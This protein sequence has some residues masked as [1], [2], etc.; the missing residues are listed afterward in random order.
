[1]GTVG[2]ISNQV[3]TMNIKSEN[4]VDF[5][6][7][8]GKD[9]LDNDLV[10]NIP[11]LSHLLIGGVDGSGKSNLLHR[12]IATLS[13]CIS[14]QELKLIL[15]DPKKIEL[16]MYN[17]LPHL[18]TPVITDP[19]K[20]ILAL[21]WAG[22]EMDRRL[23]ILQSENVRDIEAYREKGLKEDTMP[24]ILIV[25]DGLSEMIAV[26]PDEVEAVIARLS[27][28]SHLV[29][30]H[31]VLSTSRVAN[32]VI[33]EPIKSGMPSRIAFK[34]QSA[35]D[36]ISILG[37]DGAERLDTTGEILFQ[38]GNMKYPICARLSPISDAEIA[39]KLKTIKETFKEEAQSVIHPQS[40]DDAFDIDDMYE[41]AR[42]AT[43]ASG[44]VSTSYLQRKLGVGYSRAAHLIDM[45]EQKGVIGPANGSKPR[46]VIIQE[47]VH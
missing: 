37:T 18:L 11:K 46:E 35:S 31:L 8:V 7:S 25:I 26:Y 20:T 43:V 10:I 9:E 41:E 45:L 47:S 14:P 23:G 22:K 1:M 21:K 36:S 3:I 15:I 33:T 12:I 32:K 39:E 16:N 4:T 40:A 28:T 24:N 6:V 27:Q 44:K 29:G 17:H 30:I 2:I 38:S 13:S 34:V 42:E 5:G 19:K